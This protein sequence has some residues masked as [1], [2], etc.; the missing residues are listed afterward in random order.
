MKKLQW[1]LEHDPMALKG[2]YLKCVSNRNY[3]D[4][5]TVGLNY[6]I[7]DVIEDH[8]G[9]FT[10]CILDDDNDERCTFDRESIDEDFKMF[11]LASDISTKKVL[12]NAQVNKIGKELRKGVDAINKQIEEARA[13]GFDIDDVSV[14]ISY[15][16]PTKTF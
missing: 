10:L 5:F 3:S 13:Q 15:K 4:C 6:R 12:S 14:T 11:K 2:V 8:D 16:Q 1:Y 7:N 9:N